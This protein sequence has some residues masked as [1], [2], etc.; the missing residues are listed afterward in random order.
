MKYS[1]IH[2]SKNLQILN[3]VDSTSQHKIA[4]R[5]VVPACDQSVCGNHVYQSIWSHC[6]VTRFSL[7]S[8]LYG[9]CGLVFVLAGSAS[10]L[11]P[12]KFSTNCEFSM[13]FWSKAG[14]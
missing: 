13:G 9:V 11:L 8:W 4:A 10:L 7:V 12:D 3:F 1:R 2:Y 6:S 5:G 14:C